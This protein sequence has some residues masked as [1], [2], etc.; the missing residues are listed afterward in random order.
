[1]SGNKNSRVLIVHKNHSKNMWFDR[2]WYHIFNLKW[3]F[4]TNKGNT[5][6]ENTI[7]TK[8]ECLSFFLQEM[9]RIFMKMSTKQVLWFV[10][11]LMPVFRLYLKVAH[12]LLPFCQ[13]FHLKYFRIQKPH[14]CIIDLGFEICIEKIFRDNFK[15]V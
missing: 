12:F 14:K 1:M 6:N 11:F 4:Y 9:S 13:P 10:A 15:I 8:W 5:F 7:W 2:M 3:T